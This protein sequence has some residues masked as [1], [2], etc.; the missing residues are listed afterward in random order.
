MGN[1]VIFGRVAYNFDSKY[2]LTANL[3]ADGSSKLH[4]D[5]RWGVFP[6]FSAAWRVSSEKFMAD[7]TWIDDFK[8]VEAGDRQVIS[9][10]LVTMLICNVIISVVL[11]GL[12]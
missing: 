7:L 9:L 11:N 5:H 6:S 3:R 4:P 10:V 1:Y 8:Y 2:L 12:R